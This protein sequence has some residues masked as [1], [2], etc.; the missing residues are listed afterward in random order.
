M[1]DNSSNMKNS[2][3]MF[4]SFVCRN[5]TGLFLCPL[6]AISNGKNLT[7]QKKL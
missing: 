6:F 7:T 5:Y 4:V 2:F 3:F 1:V